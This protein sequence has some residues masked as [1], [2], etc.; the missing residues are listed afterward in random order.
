LRNETGKP[1]EHRYEDA[2]LSPTE[3]RWQ[4]QNRTARDSRRGRMIQNHRAE[5]T[6]VHLF[7][8]P[9]A[10]VGGKTESFIYC[11]ELEIERWDGDKPITVWW[12]LGGPV[13]AELWSALRI[14][15]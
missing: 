11:G 9:T 3:F 10:K 8:R 12:R 1:E 2:S 6:H 5:G 13:P 7:V 4:S 15:R 14:N